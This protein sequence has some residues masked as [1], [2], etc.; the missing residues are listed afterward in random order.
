MIQAIQRPHSLQQR[1][2]PRIDAIRVFGYSTAI[3]M[4]LIAAGLL[5]MP[6]QKLPPPDVRERMTVIEV[7]PAAPIPEP[8]LPPKPDPK[9]VPDVPRIPVTP[10]PVAIQAPDV[11]IIVET[12]GVPTM[13]TI[14]VHVAPTIEAPSSSTG[15][16]GLVQLEYAVAPPPP[17]PRE[18]LR[19]GNAGIVL[20]QVLVDVDG[21]PLEVE[22]VEGSG[23]RS[24]D[25]AAQRHVLSRWT[26][27]PA[28]R[29]GRAVQAVG[30]VP[31][32]F[33]L[34]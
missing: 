12:D 26:F 8:V 10:T 14:Q 17:Y 4:N 28:V 27:K 33:S 13:E 34:R 21:R 3:A 1:A 9:P 11:P 23:H 22:V 30:L 5:L 25:R 19:A 15:V 20:L 2:Q 18:D 31:I 16:G 7:V 24:L 29:D 6:L 32:E